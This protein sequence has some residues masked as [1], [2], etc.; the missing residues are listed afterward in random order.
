MP[1]VYVD[2]RAM[3]DKNQQLDTYVDQIKYYRDMRNKQYRQG[4]QGRVFTTA[5]IQKKID[6]ETR[7]RNNATAAGKGDSERWGIRALELTN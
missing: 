2:Q 1:E 5:D 3:M 7:F 4:F 6:D